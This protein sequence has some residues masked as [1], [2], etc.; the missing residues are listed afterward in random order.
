MATAP[1]HPSTRP[2]SDLV[3]DFLAY[4]ELERGL[5]RNTLEA[6]RCDLLQL[7][8]FL[9]RRGVAVTQAGHGDLAAF[10]SDMAAPGASAAGGSGA[11]DDGGGNGVR[12]A[13]AS[14][15]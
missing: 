4:L 8:A 15:A 1:P 5:S 3:L 9:D 14:A 13:P 12:R 10:I 6:Y 11:R 2:F 7:G